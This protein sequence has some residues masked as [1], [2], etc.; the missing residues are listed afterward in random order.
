MGRAVGSGFEEA[1]W[2]S[3]TSTSD[4]DFTSSSESESESESV[5][6]VEDEELASLS[7]LEDESSI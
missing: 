7:L 5:A 4:S 3:T 6:K 1:D 2:G